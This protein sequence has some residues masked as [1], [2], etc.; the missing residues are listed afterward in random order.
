M[1]L[2]RNANLY[3]R[4]NALIPSGASLAGGALVLL[5][6]IVGVLHFAAPDL[7]TAVVTPAWRVGNGA[8]GAIETL[9]APLTNSAELMRERDQLMRENL[10]LAET[11]RTLRTQA[12]DLKRLLG[13]RTEA[14]SGIPA[15]VLAR[16]PV[17]AYDTLVVGAGARQGVSVGAYAYGPGGV[18]LGTVDSVSGATTRISL[19]STGGRVT[20]GWVGEKRVPISLTGRGGGAFEATLPRESEIAVNDVVFVPGPGALP[21]GTV[22]RIDSNPSSPRAVIHIAPYADLFS[23]TWVEIAH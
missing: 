21:I 16:P 14:V 23:L 10:A 22:V 3:R 19:F 18:P 6:L 20:E 5:A 2:F 15:G 4:R 13:D 8:S 12:E 17:S 7:L 1:P 11:N 9:F